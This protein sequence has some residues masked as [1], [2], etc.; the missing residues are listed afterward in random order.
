MTIELPD[1]FPSQNYVLQELQQSDEIFVS[2]LLNILEKSDCAE[3]RDRVIGV[4]IGGS[5]DFGAFAD[6]RLYA[7]EVMEALRL[8]TNRK[9]IPIP[10]MRNDRS[11]YDKVEKLTVSLREVV[12]LMKD[13]DI[14]EFLRYTDLDDRSPEP[15]PLIA[16]EDFIKQTKLLYQTLY[17]VSKD[18]VRRSG[19]PSLLKFYD[20]VYQ[21]LVLYE[22]LSGKEFTIY[23]HAETQ[24]TKGK[25][26][27]P[28]TRGHKFVCV[29]VEWMHQNS[30]IS[31]SYGLRYTDKNIYNACEKAK[32]RLSRA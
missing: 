20:F 4:F 15:Y 29:I 31:Q 14:Q 30:E 2:E 18:R 3:T 10:I 22:S 26:Y 8:S 17:S 6:F 25:T 21:L 28:I 16:R 5:R 27:L 11:F 32:T 1:D 19:R 7:A 13:E 24:Q 23:R 12:K 9:M